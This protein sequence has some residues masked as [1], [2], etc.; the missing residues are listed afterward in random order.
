MYAHIMLCCLQISYRSSNEVE[1]DPDCRDANT[2]QEG[3]EAMKR[4]ISKYATGVS[5]TPSIVEPC[6]L[7]VSVLSHPQGL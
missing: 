4:F 3:I 6:I 1:V 5:S 7:T 2:S